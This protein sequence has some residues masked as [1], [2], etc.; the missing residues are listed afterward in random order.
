MPSLV[1]SEMCIRD[2]RYLTLHFSALLV[3]HLSVGGSFPAPASLP[4]QPRLRAWVFL[5]S[6]AW[7]CSLSATC[8]VSNSSCQLELRC[9]K[10]VAVGEE[11]CFSYIPIDQPST[12]RQEQLRCAQLVFVPWQHDRSLS[13]VDCVCRGC[14]HFHAVAS[15]QI[16]VERGN[17]ASVCKNKCHFS[18]SRGLDAS[19]CGQGSCPVVDSF[20]SYRHV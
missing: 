6:F 20:V 9:T 14:V 2:S 1:G 5:R 10:P 15:G 8:H 18:S 7:V 12:L 17:N 19:F 4:S 3:R 13:G 11:L 16:A